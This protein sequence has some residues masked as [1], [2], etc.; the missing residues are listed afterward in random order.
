MSPMMNDPVRSPQSRADDRRD[1]M[2][3]FLTHADDTVR[4]RRTLLRAVRT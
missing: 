4:S 3:A 1:G 2:R